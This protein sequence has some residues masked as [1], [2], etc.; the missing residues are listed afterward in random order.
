MPP[1]NGLL[2]RTLALICLPLML[3]VAVAALAAIDF[4]SRDADAALAGRARQIAQM[5]AGGAAEILWHVDVAAARELILPV[6]RDPD[7]VAVAI[8]DGDGVPVAALGDLSAA[9][10]GIVAERV[11]LDRTLPGQG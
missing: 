9:G 6:A 2:V 7:F 11:V 10:P 8:L 5:L 3:A 4:T 1:W